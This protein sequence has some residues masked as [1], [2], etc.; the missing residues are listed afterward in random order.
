MTIAPLFRRA[1]VL[2]AALACLAAS[3]CA[4]N[5][6]APAQPTAGQECP[7]W[8]NDP[9]DSHSNAESPY[10]GCVN[11]ANLQKLVARPAD[12]DRG[13]PLGPASGE[14]ESLGINTYE[15]NKI[16]DFDTNSVAG[17]TIVMPGGGSGTQ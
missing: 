5:D 6:R 10:L 14:R 3:A 4:E 13:R 11:R 8:V 7:P 15:T 1:A 9:T 16:K 17:P 2:L 12:L